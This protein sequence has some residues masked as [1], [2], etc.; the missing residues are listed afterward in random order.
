MIESL[1]PGDVVRLKSGG[2]A[3]TIRW[4][5]DSDSGYLAWCDWFEGTEHRGH[6]FST[7]QLAK[8]DP[9]T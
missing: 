3:M 5:K 4:C 6:R 8:V 9:S 1:K 2:P 7:S